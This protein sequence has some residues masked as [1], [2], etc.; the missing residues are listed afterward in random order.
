M[1]ACRMGLLALLIVACGLVP[2]DDLRFRTYPLV[3]VPYAEAVPLVRSVAR[4]FYAQRFA[5]AG[6]F[7][8]D[9]DESTGNLRASPIVAGNRRMRLYLT[10][11]PQG[12]HT[13]LEIFALVESLQDASAGLQ[14]WVDPQVDVAFERTLYEAILTEHLKRTG[15]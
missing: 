11:T 6:G 1:R 4:E 9:W 14:T 2:N 8:F 10:L 15:R 13:M 7:T 3:D 5:N 12:N